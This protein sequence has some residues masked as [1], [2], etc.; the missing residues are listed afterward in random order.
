MSSTL[1]VG[2]VRSGK[3]VLCKHLVQDLKE[4]L[5]NA[6]VLA[7][8][9]DARLQIDWWCSNYLTTRKQEDYKNK[10]EIV[11]MDDITKLEGVH[12]NILFTQ[13]RKYNVHLFVVSQSPIWMTPLLRQCFQQVFMMRHRHNTRVTRILKEEWGFSLVEGELG[14]PRTDFY[15]FAFE[16]WGAL[17]KDRK[18]YDQVTEEEMNASKSVYFSMSN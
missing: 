4:K 16:Y 10:P 8:F 2:P 11:V 6:P 12:V 15:P 13:F 14:T 17:H 18:R 3:T 5:D 1:I 7:L 9:Q